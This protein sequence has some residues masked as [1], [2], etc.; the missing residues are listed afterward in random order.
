MIHFLFYLQL[1]TKEENMYFLQFSKLQRQTC[2]ARDILPREQD[3][4]NPEIHSRIQGL[5]NLA[6][7]SH[8]EVL[9]SPER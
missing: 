3:Q 6:E 9:R 4:V 1:P 7:S 2:T 8:R 5:E